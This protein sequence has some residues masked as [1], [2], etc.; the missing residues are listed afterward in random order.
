[1][2]LFAL[3][4]TGKIRP[5]IAPQLPLEDVVRAHQLVEQAYNRARP[6][7]SLALRPP[8]PEPMP[9]HGSIVRRERLHGL[10]KRVLPRRLNRHLQAGK[11]HS[12]D[13]SRAAH[14]RGRN[15][16]T[17]TLEFSRRTGRSVAAPLRVPSTVGAAAP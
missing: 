3:L 10:V 5:V 12:L 13:R 6:H 15:L 9:G 4:A 2:A 14:T 16:E 7:R 1:M 11:Q 8:D 17:S